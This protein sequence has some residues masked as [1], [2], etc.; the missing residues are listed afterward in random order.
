MSTGELEKYRAFELLAPS[1]PP[2]DKLV[3]EFTGVVTQ[4]FPL[5]SNLAR[6]QN[7]CDE[8]LNQI[9]SPLKFRAAAPWVLMQVAHYEKVGEN[10]K[11]AGWFS[12]YELAFGFPVEWYKVTDGAN[13]FQDWAMFYPFIFVD[14]PLSLTGGRQIFGWDKA[15]IIIDRDAPILSPN[16]PHSTITLSRTRY[17][18]PD[19]T[20]AD[21][22]VIDKRGNTQKFLAARYCRPSDGQVSGRVQPHPYEKGQPERFLELVQRRQFL[23]GRLGLGRLLTAIPD[24][25]GGSFN[26]AR[27]ML[28]TLSTMVRGEGRDV[29][30][31]RSLLMTAFGHSADFAP[32]AAG[33]LRLPGSA[34]SSSIRTG[35]AQFPIITLKELPDA[36]QPQEAYFQ[37]LVRSALTID[38]ITDGGVFFDPFSF[39][40]T[41]GIQIHLRR[42]DEERVVE[43]LGL[44]S[45]GRLEDMRDEQERKN[46]RPSSDP[47]GDILRPVLPFWTKA[48]ASYGTALEQYWRTQKTGWTATTQPVAA[49]AQAPK[50]AARFGSGSGGD[51]P[52][53]IDRQNA[54]VQ[55]FPVAAPKK[56]L[57]SLVKEY[58]C[59]PFF[60]FQPAED[61][62]YILV[63]TFGEL[64]TAEG[65]RGYGDQELTFA[66]PVK[67]TH[68]SDNKQAD[69][70]IPLFTFVGTDWNF[71]T[72]SEEFGKIAFKSTFSTPTSYWMKALKP[73]LETRDVLKVSTVFVRGAPSQDPGGEEAQER[74]VLRIQQNAG[75]VP[76][77]GDIPKG[78]QPYVTSPGEDTKYFYTIGLRQVRDA[79]EPGR[80][81]YLS[82]LSIRTCFKMNGKKPSRLDGVKVGIRTYPLFNLIETL[83]LEKADT[84]GARDKDDFTTLKTLEPMLSLSGE[85]TDNCAH[86]MCW[87]AGTDDWM[88]GLSGW[89]NCSQYHRRDTLTGQQ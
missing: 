18:Q 76:A 26:I 17:S 35:R 21:Q 88:E 59:N 64:A 66:V 45:V 33:I 9:A 34:S 40:V 72:Q 70:L 7:Y 29:G 16:E 43:T 55:I 84:Y 32:S 39:D 38:S 28:D 60:E 13:T 25:V 3:I 56:K 5:R 68:K 54:V 52:G 10:K 14:N 49:A 61:R 20:N 75:A 46:G 30:T 4:V 78:L 1:L 23:S 87:R 65:F 63:V 44:E 11:S 51:I 41:G 85:L 89:P 79:C 71:V 80:A 42:T 53:V 69:A 50:L 15:P 83:G 8:K 81:N 73:E 36:E 62:V 6:L 24:A 12:E 37:A 57:T 31:L 22:A 77:K 67:V 74:E 58:L 27:T 86:N 19:S 48:D 82:L 47:S 2:D